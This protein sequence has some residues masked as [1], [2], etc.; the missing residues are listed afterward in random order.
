LLPL[1]TIDEV[2]NE[3]VTTHQV[4]TSHRDDD[5]KLRSSKLM[6]FE[7]SIQTKSNLGVGL[8]IKRDALSCEEE[9]IS[10]SYENDAEYLSY[11]DGFDDN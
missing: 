1:T 10:Q 5:S 6:D 8:S 4:D 9:P 11:E 2:L 7:D 3:T